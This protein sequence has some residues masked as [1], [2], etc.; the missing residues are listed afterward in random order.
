MPDNNT[1]SY[2][3]SQSLAYHVLSKKYAEEVAGKSLGDIE[4]KL[5]EQLLLLQA[6][7]AKT[8]QEAKLYIHEILQKYVRINTAEENSTNSE[9]YPIGSIISISVACS[10]SES[11]V[12]FIDG[13]PKV[14]GTINNIYLNTNDP[15]TGQVYHWFQG[16]TIENSNFKLLPGVWKNRGVCG[17]FKN[18][19]VGF[20][21]YL[22]QR[23]Q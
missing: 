7:D 23:V 17:G 2:I 3:D 6:A 14:N 5:T 9:D 1:Q 16:K 10:D 18:E 19:I 12:P 4:K 15:K 8:L 11:L 22:A 13:G 21:Y 20:K